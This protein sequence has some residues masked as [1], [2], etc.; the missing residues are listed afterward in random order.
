MTRILNDLLPTCINWRKKYKQEKNKSDPLFLLG[1]GP[2]LAK[3]NISK[4]HNRF[5]MA[6]NRS[7]IAYKDWG[8]DPTYYAAL[9][10]V[11]N[12]DNKKMIKYLIDNSDIERFFFSEDFISKQ[13]FT[14][15][16]TTII[17]INS[18]PQKVNLDFSK[19][20]EVANTGLFGLQIAIK[21]LSFKTIFLLGCDA[22]YQENIKD[23][24]IIKNNI[25]FSNSNSDIN[26]FRK[27]YF[28]KNTTYNRPQGDKYHYPAW[29]LFHQKF[30]Y[31][32]DDIQVYNCSRESRLEFF[33]YINYS[34][35]L[36]WK[37]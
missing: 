1:S 34:K 11:V 8:F 17:K 22:D 30:L 31:Q 33:P 10:H 25:I 36:S 4:L 28:G 20:L 29:S 27:D 24:K 7:F 6:F 14:S 35:A 37:K 5:T 13:H 23:T 26:H 3:H 32:N 2:S 9:D 19:P 18:N 12:N 15:S 16:K 21:I